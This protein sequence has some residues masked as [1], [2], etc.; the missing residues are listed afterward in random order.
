MK[1]KFAIEAVVADFAYVVYFDGG[2]KEIRLPWN[3]RPLE[4]AH[5]F[6]LREWIPSEEM[7]QWAERA[8]PVSA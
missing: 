2:E 7:P 3:G 1:E 5:E 6:L 8:S 4:E